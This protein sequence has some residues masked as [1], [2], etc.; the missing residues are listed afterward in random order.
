MSFE[1]SLIRTIIY[2]P[3]LIKFQT[4]HCTGNIFFVAE[5]YEDQSL[6]VY[7]ASLFYWTWKS[8]LQTLVIQNYQNFFFRENPPYWKHIFCIR[9][10]WKRK[11]NYLWCF[12]FLQNMKIKSN[13]KVIGLYVYRISQNFRKNVLFLKSAILRVP[14]TFRRDMVA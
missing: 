13:S 12:S 14:H 10:S 2:V 7:D 9:S 3:W 6:I 5:V 8:E 11:L 4:V 1:L